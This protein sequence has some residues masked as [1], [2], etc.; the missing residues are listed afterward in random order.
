MRL[1]RRA[2]KY[3]ASRRKPKASSVPLVPAVGAKLRAACMRPPIASRKRIGITACLG[4]GAAVPAMG[5]AAGGGAPIGCGTDA[6]SQ[7]A[8]SARRPGRWARRQ[9]VGRRFVAVDRAL[10]AARAGVLELVDR[11]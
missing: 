3:A 1:T 7:L 5:A 4:G 9:A 2:A 6:G 8:S 11:R 10:D